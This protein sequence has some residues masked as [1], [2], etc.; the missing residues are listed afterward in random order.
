MFES[1]VAACALASKL[2]TWGNNESAIAIF[3]A[4]IASTGKNGPNFSEAYSEPSS[5]GVEAMITAT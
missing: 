5:L 4:I 3:R 1:E 2:L